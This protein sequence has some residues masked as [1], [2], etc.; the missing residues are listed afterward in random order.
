MSDET[1][2]RYFNVLSNFSLI[3]LI[4]ELQ[5]QQLRRDTTLISILYTDFQFHREMK[6]RW[7]CNGYSTRDR[8]INAGHLVL[9]KLSRRPMSLQLGRYLSYLMQY[10]VN[11]FTRHAWNYI[12]S[13]SSSSRCPRDRKISIINT[14]NALSSPKLAN[15]YKFM[16]L[17]PA[18]SPLSFIFS[19]FQSFLWNATILLSAFELNFPQFTAGMSTFGPSWRHVV[20]CN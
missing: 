13:D 20:I 4:K 1:I 18:W 5:K 14:R 12:K 8:S 15:L 3:Y 6:S 16:L 17:S 9:H 11:V 7:T 2:K 10:D 19:S